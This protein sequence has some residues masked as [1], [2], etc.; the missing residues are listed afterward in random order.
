MARTVAAKWAAPPSGRSSRSTEV[1]TTQRRDQRSAAAATLLGSCSSSTPPGCP[2]A[3]EQKRQP[4]VQTS[5]MIKKV[6]VPQPQHSPM[7]GQRASSQT[8][9]SPCS[10]RVRLISPK[11]S[12][13]PGRTFNQGGL[14]RGTGMVDSGA[15]E[16][17]AVSYQGSATRE[18]L[19]SRL[20]YAV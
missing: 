8:V 12:P 5:P 4:R 14:R 16:L 18:A 6:A 3:T 7:L 11:A 10:R 17:S 1:N 9:C 15:W 13:P 19:C 2:V 20:R